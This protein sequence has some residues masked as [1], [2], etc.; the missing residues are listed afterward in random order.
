MKYGRWRGGGAH[1]LEKPRDSGEALCRLLRWAGMPN[2]NDHS[3]HRISDEGAWSAKPAK[4]RW[5]AAGIGLLLIGTL[6]VAILGHAIADGA[7]FAFDRA[8]LLMM[9]EGAGQG[10]GMVPEGPAWL[11]KAMIAIKAMGSGTILT[12]VVLASAGFLLV[13]RHLLTAALVLIGGSTGP[14]AVAIAK[15]VFGRVR[16][17]V[18]NHLVEEGSASFPS[19]HAA[20][21]AAVY[22]TLA[23]VLVQIVQR[24]RERTYIIAVAAALVLAIGCSRVY[25]GVHWPSDVLAGWTFG[26]LWAAGWWA[27]A[28]W[29]RARFAPD[30][31]I[32]VTPDQSA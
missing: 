20:N 4:A 5:L 16:P 17:D 14:V 21:S 12:L 28:H 30:H 24:R 15:A 3:A 31:G 32:G 23:L 19:G 29:L 25:H 7:N 1:R 27:I 26:A 11:Q 2:M 13:Q 6:F 10:A 9:R 18:I 8:I 22:L